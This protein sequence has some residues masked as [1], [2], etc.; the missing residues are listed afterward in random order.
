[1]QQQI[2][3]RGLLEGG[4]KSL[5]E[6]MRQLPHKPYSIG[7]HTLAAWLD[8]DASRQRI[9]GGKQLIGRVGR[10]AGQRIE[11]SR[12]ARIGVANERYRKGG[13]SISG[14]PLGT[15][16]APQSLELFPQP[17]DTGP[18]HSPVEFELG[19]ARPTPHANTAAL[20]LE[21][22]PAPDEPGRQV[23]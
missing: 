12:L 11:Q 21:M 1:M 7:N 6:L 19:L 22:G 10:S 8:R 5:N 23:L 3:L 16:L 18:K 2:R 15:A 13:S 20:P 9:E 4:R 14:P 17:P